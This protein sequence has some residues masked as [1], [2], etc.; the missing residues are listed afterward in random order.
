M[1]ERTTW[2]TI[3]DLDPKKII[4]G[5]GGVAAAAIMAAG[6]TPQTPD[7]APKTAP[8]A[9]ALP[10]AEASPS[11]SYSSSPS[12]SETMPYSPSAYPS[13]S[14]V[15]P[16]KLAKLSEEQMRAIKLAAVHTL[17][18]SIDVTVEPYKN[19][20]GSLLMQKTVGADEINPEGETD[21]TVQQYTVAQVTAEI[22]NGGKKVRTTLLQ[23]KICYLRD[24]QQYDGPCE[25]YGIDDDDR[26]EENK[27]AESTVF[28]FETSS[29]SVATKINKSPNPRKLKKFISD[30]STKITK[31]SSSYSGDEYEITKNGS[32]FKTGGDS[33]VDQQNPSD[34]MTKVLKGLATAPEP[35]E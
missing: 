3:K 21:L 31:I 26:V 19:D 17:D 9:S 27:L 23:E 35:T 2:N 4:A 29:D 13:E 16:E 20:D 11:L 18:E 34:V 8:V 28:E 15:A 32:V 33:I 12:P 5:V 1:G 30:G 14:Y 10:T 6:C 22:L 25:P 24:G 7:S